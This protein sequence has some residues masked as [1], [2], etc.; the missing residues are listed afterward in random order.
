MDEYPEWATYVGEPGHNDRWSDNSLEAVERRKREAT[1]P[2]KAARALDRSKLGP[3]DRLNYDLFLYRAENMSQDR[4]FPDDYMPISQL[5]GVQQ[6][7]AQTLDANPAA[8]VKDYEDILSRLRR[9]PAAVDQAVLLM[10][11]GLRKGL[12]PPRVTLKAVSDQIKAYDSTD[13]E[14]SPLFEPFKSF[15]AAVA[16]TDRA[17]LKSVASRIIVAEIAPAFRKLNEFFIEKYLPRCRETI[18]W[19]ALPNGKAWYERKIRSNTTTTLTAKEIHAIGL[20]EVKRIRAEMDKVIAESGFTGDFEA[21]K[22]YLRTDSKFFYDDPKQLLT[23][24]RDIAKRVDPELIK[25]FGRLPRLPYGIVAVPAY[26][27]KA[28][29]TAY[30]NQGSLSAGR[31]GLFYANTYDLKMRPKWEMEALTL[32][33]AVPGHHLQISLAQELEGLPEFR[34]HDGHTAYV[35]GWGLYSESLGSELGMYKD[36]YSRFGQLTYE[37]WRAVRLVIDTG[38]HSMGWTRQQ[39]IDYFKANASK[40]EHDIEVEVDRYIVWPGQAL[41]YK[42]GELKLK[43]LKALAK[44]ELGDRFD[45]RAFHDAVLGM[46]SAPLSVLDAQIKDWIASRKAGR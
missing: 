7:L 22:T 16:E 2:L 39:A 36:P 14:S 12:T 26:S 11:E 21:F 40:T 5:G 30:Y 38:I 23:G 43:E 31:A 35:E 13:A 24:Y 4:E 17:R 9:I 1:A 8:S 46:G 19:S 34:R 41:A 28:Q 15:P 45:V 42:L 3:D 18:S 33:E 25:L 32:H 27:E 29:T 44:K 10:Q 20:G 6:H 37:M